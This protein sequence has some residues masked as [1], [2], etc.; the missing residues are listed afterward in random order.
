LE[1]VCDTDTDEQIREK[2]SNILHQK[3]ISWTNI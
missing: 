2:F 1:Q 3:L